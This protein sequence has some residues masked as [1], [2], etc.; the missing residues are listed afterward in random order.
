MQTNFIIHEVCFFIKEVLCYGCFM[1][2]GL[3]RETLK[4]PP[5][6]GPALPARRDHLRRVAEGRDLVRI[7]VYPGRAGSGGD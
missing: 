6:H 7:L 1:F 3:R 5:I 2:T 4:S